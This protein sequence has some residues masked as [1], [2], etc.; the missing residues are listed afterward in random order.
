MRINKIAIF[1]L[2]AVVAAGLQACHKDSGSAPLLCKNNRFVYIKG[3][4]FVALPTAFTPN[5]DG[6]NDIFPVYTNLSYD[7]CSVRVLD[8]SGTEV[9]RYSAATPR[10][11]GPE[12]PKNRLYQYYV[13][14]SIKD[15]DEGTI[16]ACS[17]LF[18]LQHG[19]KDCI[20]NARR[21][22]SARYAFPI[23]F[24]GDLSLIPYNSE[25]FCY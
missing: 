18:L 12:D 8:V 7:S 16:E 3:D 23:Q 6:I 1:L 9:Y 2:S 22:D 11:E 14:V 21:E 17:P 25:R 24:T 19:S 5:G 13:E 4:R 20:T 15:A 10:W